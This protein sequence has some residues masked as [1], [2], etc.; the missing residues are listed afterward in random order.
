MWNFCG[1]I[2]Y[3]C[4]KCKIQ[5]SIPVDDFSIECTG[6]SERS[7]GPESIYELIYDLTCT[8]CG[9]E[10]SL[11]FEASEY[12]TE[13]LNFILDNSTGADTLSEP[14]IQYLQEL[15]QAE[16]LDLLWQ[17]IPDLITALKSNPALI[18]EISSRDFEELIAEIFRKKGFHVELTKR[19]RDGGKDII[20]IST[21]KLGIKSKY[22]IECKRYAEDNKV[23][24]EVVRA[25]HGVKHTKEGPNKTI[26]A[27]TSSF[28][29]AAK[30]FVD[31]EISSSWDM[32]LADFDQ[33]MKWINSH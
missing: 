27:T 8:K 11:S 32:A 15:Y 6:G 30:D 25:L 28:T 1:D 18:R 5:N 16:D 9:N 17:S 20:A 21:D 29:K 24:V 12:P 14:G 10:I 2:E 31:N 13:I 3:E 7:M 19:T 23:G 26:I 22:F 4:H 33:I